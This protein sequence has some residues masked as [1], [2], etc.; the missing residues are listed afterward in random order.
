MLHQRKAQSLIVVTLFGITILLI[1]LHVAKD[2]SPITFNVF[3]SLTD[4]ISLPIKALSP[5]S[6]T[7]Y[8]FI[9]LG[10]SII[11]VSLVLPIITAFPFLIS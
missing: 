2:L 5:I 8:P 4:V 6:V 9:E 3:G 10:I 11:V 7:V 1:C